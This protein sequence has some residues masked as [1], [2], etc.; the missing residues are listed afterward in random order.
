M[1]NLVWQKA[2]QTQKKFIIMHNGNNKLIQNEQKVLGY[3]KMCV[4]GGNSMNCWSD[5]KK[6]INEI[7]KRKLLQ[8]T[9]MLLSVILSRSDWEYFSLC[10]Y[11]DFFIGFSKILFFYFC[12][13]SRFFTFFQFLFF[14]C[15][16]KISYCT[17][18]VIIWKI[19]FFSDLL[20][21]SKCVT[22]IILSSSTCNIYF[23]PD[24]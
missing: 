19:H 7:I 18:I 2:H 13:D 20:C 6:I 14:I 15:T 22:E 24:C 21:I 4:Q 17:G 12:L 23:L 1:Q 9:L 5:N 11:W 10:F 16:I 8:N 3:K